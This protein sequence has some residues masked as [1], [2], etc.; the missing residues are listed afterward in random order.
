[1]RKWREL[2]VVSLA[3]GM[4]ETGSALAAGYYNVGANV[5]PESPL[6]MTEYGYIGAT[7]QQIDCPSG[8]YATGL[9]IANGWVVDNIQFICSDSST[10]AGTLG[11]AAAGSG[12]YNCSGAGNSIA[13]LQIN[14]NGYLNGVCYIRMSCRD[15]TT[16]QFGGSGAGGCGTWQT[17]QTC[18][19]GY[20]ITGGISHG[21][22]VFSALGL[23]CRWMNRSP[24]PIGYWNLSE[25]AGTTATDLS[26]NSN[27][28]TYQSGTTL[29]QPGIIPTDGKAVLFNGASGY[30][31]TATSMNLTSSHSISVWFKTTSATKMGIFGF[32]NLQTGTGSTLWSSSLETETDGRLTFYFFFNNS[33]YTIT[34]TG[35]YA[36]GN[37]H[38]VVASIGLSGTQ[39]WV[40]GTLAAQNTSIN[41]SFSYAGYWRLGHNQRASAYFNGTLDNFAV[42]RGQL[43]A[44]DVAS[45]YGEASVIC[46]GAGDDCYSDTAAKAAGIA[47]TPLGKSLA[48]VDAD[49]A[50]S[51]TFKV[52]K[53]SGG[54]RVLAA[55]GLDQWSKALNGN[56]NGQSATDFTDPSIG[57]AT[58]V[59]AGRVCPGNVYIDSSNKFTTTNCLYYT[60]TYP[61]QS[62]AVAG[63]DGVLGLGLWTEQLWLV[64]NIKTCSDKGM[65]LPTLYETGANQP[66]TTYQPTSD[67]T[68]TAWGGASG[69]PGARGAWTSS[70]YTNRSDLYWKW[71]GTSASVTNNVCSNCNQVICV[72]P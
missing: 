55:N 19:P 15:G 32:E 31:S 46:G 29:N 45:I 70:A 35:T 27:T 18:P 71:S 30:M 72:V 43:S 62:L 48:Y 11:N 52:W 3:L 12:I 64:G 37:W 51:G 36:D 42:Y 40:D 53:E 2:L 56:G 17:V 50:G 24:A 68:P 54:N 9:D 5:Q 10:T 23:V 65:R 61:L 66:A 16:S 6:T 69:V 25:T 63:T 67:G 38:H 44:S 7:F 47:K 58:T 57:T 39:L 59:I 26:G 14:S 34:T 21:G 13:S 60:P 20:A 22:S 28:G 41:S 33:G 8:T 4:W 1:M 49:G